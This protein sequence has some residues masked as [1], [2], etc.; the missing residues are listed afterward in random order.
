[1]KYGGRGKGTPNKLTAEIRTIL[2]EILSNEIANIPTILEQLEPKEK[3]EYVIKLMPYVLPKT[4]T[5][6][7]DIGEP[8]TYD[9]L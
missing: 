4:N 5:V 8:T 6:H 1:M 7:Y 9:F 3:L 2:K